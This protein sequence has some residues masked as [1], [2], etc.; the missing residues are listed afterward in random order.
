MSYF[1]PIMIHLRSQRGTCSPAALKWRV[2]ALTVLESG[3]CLALH[4][5]LA[6]PNII[7]GLHSEL[8]GC[9]RF[10]PANKTKTRYT[11]LSTQ[12]KCV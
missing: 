5:V 6:V 8:V 11:V 7:S 1:G 9:E 12:L 3:D 4:T 2:V 10:E